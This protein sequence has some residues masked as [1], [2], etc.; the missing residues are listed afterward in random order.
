MRVSTAALYTLTALIAHDVTSQAIAAPPSPPAPL[1]DPVSAT[2]PTQKGLTASELVAP[3]AP[4]EIFPIQLSTTEKIAVVQSAVPVALPPAA[5]PTATEE[6]ESQPIADLLPAPIPLATQ[7][8]PETS[9][10]SSQPPVFNASSEVA[11]AVAQTAV[12]QPVPLIRTLN[13]A[14]LLNSSESGQPSVSTR[15]STVAVESLTLAEIKALQQG[16]TPNSDK[17]TV[18]SSAPA[19]PTA[20]DTPSTAAALVSANLAQQA[21]TAFADN[22][23]QPLPIAAHPTDNGQ[24][25]AAAPG[26]HD[27]ND[28]F[29]LSVYTPGDNAR[30]Y[31]NLTTHPG[32]Q[33]SNGNVSLLFPLSIPAAITSAFGWRVHPVMGGAR[34]HAGTDIGAPQ[35]TPVLAALDGKV[36]IAD[37]VGGYGLT[38][39]LQHSKGTEQTLYAHLSEIF[40]Q[41]GDTLKQGEVIGQVGSTGLSTGPHLHFEFRKLTQEGWTLIDPGPSLEYALLHFGTS[42]QVAQSN[43]E[44]KLPALFKYSGKFLEPIPIAAQINAVENLHASTANSSPTS[45]N[46][47]ATL[48]SIT[49][50]D[51]AVTR[52]ETRSTINQSSQARSP[53]G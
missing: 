3:I 18:V 36:E 44:L 45:T 1:P 34:F 46:Q 38:V 8:A 24:Q 52:V 5:L 53:Q 40:V 42:P 50:R 33:F 51:R 9:L 12:P 22:E 16:L 49:T 39:V 19:A 29:S 47:T 20:N 43:P 21:A 27:A 26:G 10:P 2:T 11:A 41:P 14:A 6:M 15:G 35:G 30:S 31:Y 25:P 23:V 17:A 4:A 37:F 48:R 28:G 32:S 7:P 13:E